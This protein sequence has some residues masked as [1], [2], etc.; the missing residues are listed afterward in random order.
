MGLISVPGAEW[1]YRPPQSE[2]FF[3]FGAECGVLPV[4]PPHPLPPR[5]CASFS[6]E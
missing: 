2:V 6:V 5:P 1:V 3:D 4:L